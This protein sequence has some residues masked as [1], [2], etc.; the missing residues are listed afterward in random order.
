MALSVCL[1]VSLSVCFQYN[2]AKNIKN[3]K[4]KHG[5]QVAYKCKE[6]SKG[7]YLDTGYEDLIDGSAKH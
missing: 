7:T 2:F 6:W 3:S 1:S 4:I 5:K